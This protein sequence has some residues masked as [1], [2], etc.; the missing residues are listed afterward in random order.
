MPKDSNSFVDQFD[1]EH[2]SNMHLH[3]MEEG[4]QFEED[5]RLPARIVVKIKSKK[6]D[7]QTN[8][9]AFRGTRKKGLQP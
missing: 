4:A 6:N 3:R 8:K 2:E 1:W 5:E 9:R 7:N